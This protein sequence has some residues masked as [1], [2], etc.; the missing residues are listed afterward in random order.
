M[1]R[2]NQRL[3]FVAL[4][5]L[6]MFAAGPS[7]GQWATGGDRSEELAKMAQNVVANLINVPFQWS[8]G[9]W[10]GPYDNA[11]QSTLNIQPVLPFPVGKD[12]NIIRRTIFPIFL[13]LEMKNPLEGMI[14]ASKCA[15]A[16]RARAHGQV[17]PAK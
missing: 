8:M 11:Y 15:S 13:I 17:D 4:A 12:W 7:H 14:N 6:V 3:I 1:R 5:A 9:F 10:T 2:P 16:Q